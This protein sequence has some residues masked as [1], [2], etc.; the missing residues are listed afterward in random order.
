ME[1]TNKK[2]GFKYS[3]ALFVAFL[4]VVFLVYL[5]TREYILPK[6]TIQFANETIK[7]EIAETPLSRTRGLK[8]HAP[9]AENEGMLF[10]FSVA[11]RHSFWMKDMK[12]PIDIVWFNQGRVVDIAPNVPISVTKDLPLYTPRLPSQSALELKAGFV[13]RH[14]VKI[15]D[16]ITLLTK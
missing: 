14:G 6:A 5:K 10:L 1:D 2:F 3:I 15:G 7:V 16:P 12:F 8:S 9:L 13:E 4:F 11:D